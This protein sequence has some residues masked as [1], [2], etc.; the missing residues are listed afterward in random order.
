MLSPDPSLDRRDQIVG[1]KWAA[2]IVFLGRTVDSVM[3]KTELSSPTSVQEF[4]RG[5]VCLQEA[6]D[7][8]CRRPSNPVREKKS[9]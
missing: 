9:R 4:L 3:L 8:L 2:H 6:H 1:D 5:K 7:P